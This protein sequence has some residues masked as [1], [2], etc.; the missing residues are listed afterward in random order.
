M[1]A[2][3]AFVCRPRPWWKTLGILLCVG[4]VYALPVMTIPGMAAIYLKID[5]I[6]GEVTATGHEKWI[7]V[8]S[9]QWGVGRGV[10]D[11]G[12]GRDVTAP[13]FS[14]VVVTKLTDKTTPLIFKESVIGNGKNVTLH[15]TE[16]S[17]AT[18]RTYQVITLTDVLVSGFSQNSG[19]DRPAESISF[20]FT[21]LV[22]TNTTFDVSGKAVGT[23]TAGYDLT[24]G[25]GF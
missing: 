16:T 11:P 8:S 6:D 13:S 10:G 18:E 21:K 23:A 22:L 15:F 19:G 14:E 3:K 1:K 24:T 4:L 2:L 7:E 17:N 5:G 12:S 25:K 20:N 9:A